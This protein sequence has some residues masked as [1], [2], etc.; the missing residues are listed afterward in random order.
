MKDRR[1]PAALKLARRGVGAGDLSIEALGTSVIVEG[2]C[3]D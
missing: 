2:V 1:L 3:A